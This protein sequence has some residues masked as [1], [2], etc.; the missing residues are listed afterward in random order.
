M[1]FEKEVDCMHMFILCFASCCDKMHDKVWGKIILAQFEETVH[2]GGEGIG[3]SKGCWLRCI[4][5]QEVEMDE[6]WR[7]ANFLLIFSSESQPMG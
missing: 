5:G 4:H 7:S 1:I 2:H 6:W 3:R